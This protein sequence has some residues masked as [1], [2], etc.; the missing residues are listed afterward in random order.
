LFFCDKIIVNVNLINIPLYVKK[1]G[2]ELDSVICQRS[3]NFCTA[4]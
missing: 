1:T 4:G 3:L 2:E